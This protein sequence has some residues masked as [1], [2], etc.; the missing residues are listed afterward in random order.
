MKSADPPKT[1]TATKNTQSP[2][3]APENTEPFFAD[4]SPHPTPFSPK[5]HSSPPQIQKQ[6]REEN[7][8]P[9]S[10]SQG[11]QI[12]R[13]PAEGLDIGQGVLH[14]QLEY[15][16]TTLN[17]NDD[18]TG[19]LRIN[20]GQDVIFTARFLPST[21]TTCPRITFIQSVIATVGG[22]PD[23]G[24][25]L[26]FTDPSTGAS[27]D[28]KPGESEPYYGAAGVSG[29]T[30]LVGDTGQSIGSAGGPAPIVATHGDAPYLHRIPRGMQAIRRFEAAVICVETGETWG[31]IRWG[32][33]KNSNGTIRL[34]GAQAGDVQVGTASPALEQS[35]QDF[36]RGAFQHSINNFGIGSSSLSPDH[37]RILASIPRGNLN[38]IRLVG[39]NDNSGGAEDRADLSLERAN[40]VKAYLVSRLGISA[41]IIEVEGHGVAAR[42]L[43][44]R[45][46]SVAANRRVDI[47]FEQ[48]QGGN[49][50][51]DLPQASVLGRP[52]ERR[53]VYNQNPLATVEEAVGWIFYLLAKDQVSFLEWDQLTNYLRALAQWRRTDPTIPDLRTL[54]RGAILRIRQRRSD[55]MPRDERVRPQGPMGRIEPPSFI[56]NIEEDAP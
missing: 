23:V 51:R 29:S 25:F 46:T 3:F 47:H 36:Y 13:G 40:A 24:P 44:P 19:D 56:P 4:P 53:R 42:E 48:G 26:P 9:P 54:Y 39:A 49:R 5:L 35:R 33:V 31:S 12:R 21:T 6:D 30:G 17:S 27:L 45:G 8:P 37:H 22:L 34:L 55:R 16:G 32:Y 41:D 38:S 15:K 11:D 20:F 10:R 14:W 43:N 1:S 28:V 7:P 52:G 18:G 50:Q 2:F